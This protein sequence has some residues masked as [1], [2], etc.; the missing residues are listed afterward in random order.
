MGVLRTWAGKLRSRVKRLTA[1]SRHQ[2]TRRAGIPR[3]RRY[4]SDSVQHTEQY[5]QAAQD[6]VA[7]LSPADQA[8][9]FRKPFDHTT[10]HPAFFDEL[11]ALLNIIRAM[12][13]APGGRVLEVGSG[14]GWVTE[15]LM[16]LG[17]AVDAL[18]PST[19]M[20]AVARQRIASARSHYRLNEPPPVEF[21]AEAIE[22][23]SL[24]SDRFDAVLFHAALHHII[25]EWAGL[26][27]CF[28]VLRPGGVLG[29]SEGAWVPGEGTWEKLLDEAM[30]KY[31][32]LENPFTAEYLDYVLEQCGFVDIRRY[33]A[34]NGLLPAEVGWRPVA[35]LA[36]SGP[37]TGNHLTAR[38]PARYA[39]STLDLDRRT[40]GVIEILACAL[41]RDSGIARLK[42]RV[43]NRGETTWL[44]DDRAQGWVSIALRRGDPGAEDFLEA[45]SR[46]R[47]PRELDPGDSLVTDLVYRLPPGT[48]GDTWTLDLVNEGLF[49]FSTRGT[50]PL[51]VRW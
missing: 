27:Q 15:I 26:A 13:I 23:C 46:H 1:T 40:E 49:W 42:V 31:G 9:L 25:D 22:S 11:Y 16:A 10:G 33:Y 41:D 38:K 48:L 43:R 8:W 36:S 17:Y 50:A 32:A 24:G 29:V 44:A 3:R 2:P 7:H 39:A 14:P 30:S 28:R 21:H 20:I 4:L 12:G 35:E 19:D 37:V 34:V 45:A 6:Y 51:A 47:L 18:E 5:L